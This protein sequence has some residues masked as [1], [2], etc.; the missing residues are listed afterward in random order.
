MIQREDLACA[1]SFFDEKGHYCIILVGTS[2]FFAM[3]FYL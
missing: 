2:P 3:V 1:K